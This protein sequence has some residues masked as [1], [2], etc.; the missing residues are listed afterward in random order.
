[1]RSLQKER[2]Y[3][4][5]KSAVGRQRIQNRGKSKSNSSRGGRDGGGRGRQ[6]EE[7]VARLLRRLDKNGDGK[8]VRSEV[9]RAMRRIFDRVD[10]DSDGEVDLKDFGPP[11]ADD[12]EPRRRR[13]R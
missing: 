6:V 5:L 10:E 2:D 12:E 9:P 4:K 11:P 8:L 3:R 13:R 7:R 1:M